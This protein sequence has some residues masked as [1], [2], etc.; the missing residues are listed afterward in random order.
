MP[1]PDAF[2]CVGLPA[3]RIDMEQV[4]AAFEMVNQCRRLP[5]MLETFLGEYSDAFNLFPLWNLRSTEDIRK[6]HYLITREVEQYILEYE[7]FIK[8]LDLSFFVNPL[9]RQPLIRR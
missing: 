6:S 2:L 8:R 7:V 9:K 4:R 1:H 5:V 3:P